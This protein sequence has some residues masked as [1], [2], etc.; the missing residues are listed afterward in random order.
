M[1]KIYC[2]NILIVNISKFSKMTSANYCIIWHFASQIGGEIY[3]RDS[4]HY[5]IKLGDEFYD[6]R[7]LISDL[8]EISKISLNPQDFFPRDEWE[9]NY[10]LK[11]LENFEERCDDILD[12][13]RGIWEHHVNTVWRDQL[14][15]ELQTEHGWINMSSVSDFRLHKVTTK[16]NETLML[17]IFN[18]EIPFDAKETI[19]MVMELSDAN[20]G[21]KVYSYGLIKPQGYTG[22]SPF[23]YFITKYYDFSLYNIIEKISRDY[24]IEEASNQIRMVCEPYWKLKENLTKLGYD[25]KIVNHYNVF[26]DHTTAKCVLVELID[27]KRV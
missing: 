17:R 23:L 13:M 16:D 15:C 7:G 20:I 27:L 18:P 1:K 22:N 6:E 2:L 5:C 26:F 10:S 3:T 24:D 12:N 4:H 11:N 9:Y 14:L 19:K 21:P 25:E 8:E